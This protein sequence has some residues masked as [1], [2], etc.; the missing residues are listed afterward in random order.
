VLAKGKVVGIFPEGRISYDGRINRFRSGVAR[1]AAAS[2]APVIPV[3]VRGAFESLPRTKRFPMPRKITVRV[4]ASLA[5]PGSPCQDPSF[6]DLVMFR[7]RAF[8]E[9]C[10]LSGQEE[11][12]REVL[13]N[14]SAERATS[15]EE[16]ASAEPQVE[17][18]RS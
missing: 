5:F 8:C 4:G 3:G 15:G 9:V 12:I 16:P 6:S 2:G 13:K 14:G 17:A 18:P 1:I 10:R 11:R 7:D